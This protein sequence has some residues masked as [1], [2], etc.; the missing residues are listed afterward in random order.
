MSVV[1]KPDNNL[2]YIPTGKI[3]LK[4]L[5]L[6]TYIQA[7][8]NG[9]ASEDTI[10]D[11]AIKPE[12]YISWVPTGE[13]GLKPL[14]FAAYIPNPEKTTADLFRLVTKSE[15][16]CADTFRKVA[17]AEISSADLLR[18]VTCS[19][20]FAADTKREVH[21][22]ET[23]S[24]DTFRRVVQSDKAAADTFREVKKS[25]IVIADTSRKMG[26]TIAIADTQRDIIFSTV[27][28][29]DTCRKIGEAESISA[30]TFLR[31]ARTNIARADL[32]RKI[33]ATTL[34]NSDTLRKVGNIETFS[35]DTS[36][37]LGATE[38]THVDTLRQVTA[39]EIAIGD[40]NRAIR[41]FATAD[42]CRQVTRV[43]R[44][45]AKTVIRLPHVL[46]Y[47]LQ[48]QLQIF[49]AA[50]TVRRLADNNLFSLVNTFKDYGVTA[51]NITL[52][53]R[54]LSDDFRF[55]IAS[56]SM[57]INETVQG[58]LL[59][60][61]FHFLVEETTQTDL[62]QSVKG[63]YNVDD[64]LYTQFFI[65]TIEVDLGDGK[66][67]EIP[68]G[69]Y[70]KY[71]DGSAAYLYPKAEEIIT[72]V[73]D[74]FDL[75]SDVRIDD[76][77]PYNLSGDHRITYSDLLNSVFGWTS[78]LPQRQINVFIRGG[79]LHCIQRGKEISVF[80][81]TTLPHSHP[82]VNKKLIR[83]LWSNPKPDDSDSDDNP[84]PD[85][86]PLVEYQYEEWQEPFSG[87]ISFSDD[88]C[89]TVLYYENG[90]LIRESNET[91]NAKAEMSSTV[92]YS[93]E[94]IFPADMSAISIEL[95]KGFDKH[96]YG[97]FYLST[98]K[99]NASATTD[100]GN[101][102]SEQR[103]TTNYRYART[104]GN[105]LYLSSEIDEN[106]TVTYKIN[107]KGFWEET[108]RDN[109]IRETFHVPLG[110]GWYGQSVY[111]NG[112]AQGSNISQGAPG[113]KVSQY[114]IGE[115]QK[116]FKGW[117]ITYNNSNADD[118]DNDDTDG[119]DYEDWR[120]KLAPIADVSF[121]VREL[122]L[123]MTLTEE[124]L[125]LNR[126]V[127]E[128]VN[129]DL[130]AKVYNGVP[131]IQHIVDFTERIMFDGAEY[132]LVSNRITF[133]PRKLIQKLQLIRWY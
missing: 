45:I 2:S 103:G 86:S 19:E 74:Y 35:G 80:D 78:R 70:E 111:H 89:S 83:S 52:S 44:A 42:T 40:L 132:F 126:K 39:T 18:Q 68:G 53:E 54:T 38:K 98:K 101:K 63:R 112:T 50:S 37:T 22:P 25:E 67:V 59:D 114:M 130:I 14:I 96:F 60:Y 49:K 1:I 13:V 24:G 4:P 93:Y 31:T 28:T 115:V 94:E 97:D 72:K 26:I 122:D 71:R 127:Q 113:N 123:L 48:S 92:T 62:V 21:Q 32:F 125:W 33:I 27:A 75:A 77:T 109:D 120:R 9:N 73:A 43:E 105:D 51:I 85:N 84:K 16:T 117:T 64:L 7:E 15:S 46:N 82:T 41:A 110:N 55:D 61:P 131:S 102:R 57:G 116:T 91:W 69:R 11:T 12:I 66:T 128:T 23:I 107:D 108:D 36:R 17:E 129:V 124:L 119:D 121:P 56:R 90:L 118:D 88:G 104:E 76:F 20:S 8:T 65:A 34:A 58:W 133:T 29:F 10:H 3:G 100:N 79:T 6:A 87:T 81:I 106:T 30:D 5:I 99:L 95:K 47:V